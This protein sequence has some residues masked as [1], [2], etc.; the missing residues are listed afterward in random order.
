MPQ[1]IPRATPASPLL[2]PTTFLG[3]EAKEFAMPESPVDHDRPN[4]VRPAAPRRAIADWEYR[5]AYL[6]N[7]QMRLPA[8]LHERL[9][10]WAER[11]RRPAMDLLID[12]LQEAVLRRGTGSGA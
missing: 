4:P 2:L 12:L 9:R 5:T 8:E 10:G 11:D 1:K 7:F 6:N 3:S